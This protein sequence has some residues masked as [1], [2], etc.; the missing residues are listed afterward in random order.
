VFSFHLHLEQMVLDLPRTQAYPVLRA[1]LFLFL[2]KTTLNHL[3]EET[4]ET[5]PIR[6]Y[7]FRCQLCQEL[8]AKALHIVPHDFIT[9]L[10]KLFKFIIPMY[11]TVP[12]CP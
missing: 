12:T 5:E 9:L 6:M 8:E 3:I 11:P 7:I 1:L 2:H 4:T 10:N